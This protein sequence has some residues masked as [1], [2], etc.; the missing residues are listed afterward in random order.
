MFKTI[1][2]VL[3]GGSLAITFGFAAD[4]VT[5]ATIDNKDNNKKNSPIEM[6]NKASD[7]AGLLAA[8]AAAYIFGRSQ[9]NKTP[10]P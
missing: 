6:P 5:Q 7:F 10:K 9:G 8:G 1:K 4:V 2:N 3:I